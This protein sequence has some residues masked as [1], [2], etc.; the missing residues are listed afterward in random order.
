MQTTVEILDLPLNK[1]VRHTPVLIHQ[2][3][4]VSHYMNKA[5]KEAMQ[6]LGGITKITNNTPNKLYEKQPSQKAREGNNEKQS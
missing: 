4:E 5:N 2:L 3:S 6:I 1:Q